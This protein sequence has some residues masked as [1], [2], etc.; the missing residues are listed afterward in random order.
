[1]L[2]E[3][4]ENY[5]EAILMLE[6][7]GEVRSIDIAHYMHVSRP[8][9]NKAVNLLKKKEFISQEAYGSVQLTAKGRTMAKSIL[10]RHH[11]IKVF[12]MEV[13]QV[14]PDVADKDACRIE[15]ILS[16]ETYEKLVAFTKKTK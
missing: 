12:L 11:N 3:S 7:D 15:H 8:S 6:R 4:L 2:G 1:M 13:L 10:E 5:L 14:S 9:V 16:Q